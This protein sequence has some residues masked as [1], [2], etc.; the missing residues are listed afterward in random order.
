MKIMHTYPG[1]STIGILD[2]ISLLLSKVTPLSLAL[3]DENK[4][5]ECLK[6]NYY[7]LKK[8]KKNNFP[9]LKN[10]QDFIK[11]ILPPNKGEN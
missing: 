10:K 2:L 4:M 8:I 11:Y 5:L 7:F 9:F 3:E 1:M 6:Y